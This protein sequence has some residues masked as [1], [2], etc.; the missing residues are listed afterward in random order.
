MIEVAAIVITALVAIYA[1]VLSTWTLLHQMDLTERKIEID[2]SYGFI[3][4]GPDLGS[5]MLIMTIVNPG[6]KSV[7]VQSPT[8]LL[9]NGRQVVFLHPNSEVQFPHT[10]PEG[11]NCHSWTPLVELASQIQEHGL[12]GTVEL[13]AIVKDQ[14]GGEYRSEPCPIDVSEWAS[15]ATGS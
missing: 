13:V 4:R 1:A 6:H 3:P 8:L 2:I 15:R 14:V 9:P 12:S 11:Q 5:T 10:L 7:A